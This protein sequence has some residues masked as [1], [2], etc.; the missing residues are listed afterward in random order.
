MTWTAL[1]IIGAFGL[2]ALGLA[3]WVVTHLETSM[4]QQIAQ[5][6]ALFGATF[7]RFERLV[8]ARFSEMNRKFDS[9]FSEM[10]RR[11][12]LV[13][14]RLDR[15]EGHLDRVEGRLDR[16]E[17]RLTSLEGGFRDL[18]AD[19]ADHIAHHSS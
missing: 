9:R 5:Q 19:L 7:D 10:D 6:G 11:F 13:D 14:Q 2:G 4:G 12:D 15:V 8:D 3:T 1:G 17:D 18:R 16:V